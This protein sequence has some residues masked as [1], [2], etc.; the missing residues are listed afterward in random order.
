M[1][2]IKGE[3]SDAATGEIVQARVQVLSPTGENVAPAD[4][5]WKVG[6]GE[7]FFYSE[8]QFSLETTHG[9]HRVLVERGTEFT[10]W[11][12][13]VEVDGSL[14]SSVDVVLERWTDLP[15]RGRHP[16]N[17]HIHYCLLYTSDSADDS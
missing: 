7:P 5:M 9:Y 17:A 3:I 4:A 2:K 14:D 16:G 11:E 13:I 8:G 1:P 6:S 12:G 10:P 15:E